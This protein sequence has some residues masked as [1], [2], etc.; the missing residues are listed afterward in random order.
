MHRIA[1]FCLAAL[2]ILACGCAAKPTRARLAAPGLA[3][4]GLIGLALVERINFSLRSEAMVG[5]VPA[6]DSSS[7]YHGVLRPGKLDLTFKSRGAGGVYLAWVRADWLP[8]GAGRVSIVLTGHEI[9]TR[10]GTYKTSWPEDQVPTVT[11]RVRSGRITYLGVIKRTI[12]MPPRDAGKEAPALR[13]RLTADPDPEGR[14]ISGLCLDHPWF[15]KMLLG[16]S[17]QGGS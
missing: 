2:L 9:R 17:D 10:A 14:A 12:L 5:L 3:E 16:P 1:S 13:V 4:K 11:G 6:P 7:I 15:K 8:P